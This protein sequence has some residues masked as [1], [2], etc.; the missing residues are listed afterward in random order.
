M[1]R[2]RMLSQ[3]LLVCVNLFGSAL[4]QAPSVARAPA[5]AD[6]EAMVQDDHLGQRVA[7]LLLL[8]RPDV[9]DDLK[10]TPEQSTSAHRAIDDLYRRALASRNLK[11]DEALAAR[12]A[13]DDAQERWIEG[14]LTGEQRGR[15]DQIDLQW[16]GPPALISRPAIASAL[17]LKSE[18]RAVLKEAVHRRLALRDQFGM[19]GS[20]DRALSHECLAVLDANQ[21]ALY[22]AML[23]PPFIPSEFQARR[24][25]APAA[26]RR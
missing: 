11:G 8:G 13:V 16:E 10:L 22:L 26:A 25:P 20:D 14:E 2:L 23:G 21:R 17:G 18:Q 6:G 15:L 9:R 19:R 3:T 12:R 1:P 5:T 24:E 4:A 7:R